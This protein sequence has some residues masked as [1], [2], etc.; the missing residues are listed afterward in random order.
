MEAH[1]LLINKTRK[2]VASIPF[3]KIKEEILG[4]SYDLSVAII[5][6]SEMR[7]AMKYKKPRRKV[8]I[9]RRASG[10]KVSNVLSFPYSKTSGEILLCPA[11][12]KPYSLGYLFIHGC[13]H[14]KGMGHGVRMDSTER[15]LL[16]QFAL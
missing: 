11:A 16:S 1:F 6:A 8:G 15:T 10:D 9:P 13:L 5:G 4:T 2:R 3:Q 12:A 14:L 7:K